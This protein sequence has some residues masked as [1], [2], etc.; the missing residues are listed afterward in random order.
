MQKICMKSPGFH[1]WVG[2]IFLVCCGFS[3]INGS[4]VADPATVVMAGMTGAGMLVCEFSM[5]D[6]RRRQC[7]PAMVL[8]T[9]H[10]RN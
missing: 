7:R 9:D 5:R 6:R 2:V 8:V 3:V 4:L 10:S 1:L